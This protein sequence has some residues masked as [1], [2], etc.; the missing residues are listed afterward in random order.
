MCHFFQD[1]SD[2]LLLKVSEALEAAFIRRVTFQ[3]SLKMLGEKLGK[4]R[5]GCNVHLA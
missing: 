5:Q 2:K 1:V 3:K 4:N